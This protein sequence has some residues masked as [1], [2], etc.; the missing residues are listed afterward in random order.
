MTAIS[1]A[2]IALVAMAGA[3]TVAG[4]TAPGVVGESRPASV[5]ALGE[6][7]L[8]P[9]DRAGSADAAVDTAVSS[10]S[11]AAPAS[12]SAAGIP[13]NTPV[14]LEIAAALSSAKARRGD[15]FPLRLAQP[16][17]LAGATVLPA[18][19]PGIGEVVHAARRGASGKPGELLLAARYL[20]HQ[21]RRV[22]LRGFS[23]GG[24]GKSREGVAV[25]VGIALGIPG[26]FVTGGEIEIPA[27]TQVG[28]R[29]ARAVDSERSAA[30]AASDSII[31]AT[32]APTAGASMSAASSITGEVVQ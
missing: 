1:S 7:P 20:E 10:A 19:T 6:A 21:G 8:S 18:G 27:G 14:T 4:G 16:L 23:L 29:T 32:A 2:L 26:L 24:I 12:L 3:S 9:A 22:A 5:T 17:V 13:A 31:P 15:R 11:A 25:S 28:A 30:P